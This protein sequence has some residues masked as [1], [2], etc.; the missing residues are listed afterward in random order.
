MNFR[1]IASFEKRVEYIIISDML[2]KGLDIYVPLVVDHGVDCVIKRKDGT[3]IEVQI[4]GRSQ[5]A[6]QKGALL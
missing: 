3:F 1:D 5:S 4:K 6:K 2:M